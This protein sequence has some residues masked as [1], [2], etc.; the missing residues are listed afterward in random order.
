MSEVRQ[1]HPLKGNQSR[2]SDPE[3]HI[4]LSASAGTGKTQVLAAR[5]WRLLLHGTDPGA[6]L[7]LTFTKAGA[8]EMSERVTSRLA[9]W[10]RIDES[11]LR[12]DLASLGETATEQMIGKARQLFA[13]VL[14]APGGGIRIQTIH[15]FCQSLLAAF[16]MEAGLVPG[17]RPLDQREEAVLAREALAEMLVDAER[18]HRDWVVDAVGALSLRLGEGK[19]EDFLKACA[20]E[21]ES[22]SQ[23]PLLI[24]PYLREALGLPLGDIDAEITRRCADDQ[25]D[26]GSLRALTIMNADW[27]TGRGLERA[28]IAA[29]WLSRSPEAR[30]AGLADL[31]GIWA[32]AKGE[33]RSFGKGQ[34]PQEPAYADYAMRL[35]ESCSQL[36]GMKTQAAYADLLARGLEAGRVYAKTYAQAKRRLGAVDFNDL[37]HRTVALLAEPGMGEWV[38]YKLD[39]A[40]EHVLIDE[41]QDTNPQQ[42]QIVAAIADEFFVGE[43]VRATT[44]RTLFTVGDYKQA[45]FGFQGTDPIFFR[46]AFER[47]LRL[48]RVEAD[49]DYEFDEGK[50]EPREVEELS[51]THSFR[52][53]RPVLEFVDA[54]LGVLPLPGMGEL[55]DREE[56]A[57]EVPGPGSV[58]L[59]P[60][61]T[62]GGSEADEEEWVS[63]ATRKLAGDIAKAIKGWIGTLPLESKG[64]MLAPEDVMILVKRRGELA[65][66]IVARLY[67]EGVP[68]AGVDRLRLNAPLAVQDLLA[69][70]RFALQPEDDLSLASLLVSPLIGWSQQELLDAAVRDVGGLWRHLRRTQPEERLAPLYAL[71]ARADIATPYR[72]LE[73]ILSGPLDGRR[74]LL[75]R[76]GEE[77][78]DPIEE[79]LNAT[80]NF[81][82]TATPSLQRFLDWFDRGDVEI[83]R[84]AAQPQ[85]AV[86]VMTAHGAKGLQAP[87]VI[88]ADATV[89]PTRSPRDFLGWEVSEAS[90]KLPIF[91]PRSSERGAL[92]DVIEAADARELS[93]HWRLFYVA[94]TRAEEKLVVAGALGPMAKG[95]PPAKSWYAAS[96]AALDALGVPEGEVREFRGLNPQPPVASRPRPAE[97]TA[98]VAVL[99]GW[100]RRPA[101]EEAS[102]PRPLAPSSLGDDAV[103]DPPPTPAMRAAA[104]RGRLL[105]ALF[106][107][108]P[109]VSP[110]DRPAAAERWLAGA[111]GVADPALRAELSGAALAVTEDSRFSALFGPDSLGEAPIAAVVGE[112]LVVSGTVDRLVVTDSHVRVIDFKTGRRAPASLEA[113]PP[114]H[115]RQ[116]AAYAAALAVIFPGRTVE[117]GLLYAAGPVLHL[118]PP[119]LL[120]AHKPGLLPMEQSLGS[121]A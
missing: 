95:M 40:T 84:D 78:R 89:D 48:S 21:R 15:S 27:G 47:F 87:L 23:L 62:E 26:L 53:T 91:R 75:R 56:H 77:A 1:L 80:L 107:R 112:G 8:A 22:L 19:A 82:K 103:A 31:H 20:R 64:R 69:A 81:E 55:S 59:W 38:R 119:D 17:F 5:V 85:G 54:A 66:L 72:F 32:T 68:V 114:Y 94:A 67:A 90:G 25:F 100:A 57:S 39:Q 9:R 101:P 50:P 11:S 58:T 105:H 113:I 16:P 121:R 2:A 3:R 110:A 86:R 73:E 4:W 63:D 52:S 49:P 96:A 61:V 51:L 28:D 13:K 60:P 102:P 44:M 33:P 116:M 99:P 120:A 45:I 74:K 108:L 24:Q 88:L 35:F 76:L 118:L 97:I 36:L 117:A 71:L 18:E 29:A 93:E 34:A 42:W 83:V 37:I 6:I 70:I 46:A 98:E 12:A 43:G 41:A 30:A 65:S 115:L 106:E 92:A 109:S 79:L 104:E 14:D 111:G 10:V 7:C